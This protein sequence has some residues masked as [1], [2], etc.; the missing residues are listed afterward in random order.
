MADSILSIR[1]RSG[2]AGSSTHWWSLSPPAPP[3]YVVAG[4][5]AIAAL[6]SRSPPMENFGLE[7]AKGNRTGV[8]WRKAGSQ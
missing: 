8:Y 4:S 5:M 2:R 7:R 6:R 1:C 3:F